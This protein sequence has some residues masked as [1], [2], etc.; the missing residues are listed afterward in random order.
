MAFADANRGALSLILASIAK[1]EVVTYR[2]RV[3][4]KEACR[5]GSSVSGTP[6]LYLKSAEIEITNDLPS[7][8]ASFESS[9]PTC[10]K[11]TSMHEFEL[12]KPEPVEQRRLHRAIP[13]VRR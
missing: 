2:H 3:T 10:T 5:D 12:V 11:M 13:A 1:G 8:T 9:D 7:V 6:D 4:P